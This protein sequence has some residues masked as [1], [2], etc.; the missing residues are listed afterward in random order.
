MTAARAAATAFLAS[1]TYLATNE[2]N[3]LSARQQCELH[4]VFTIFYMNA[5]YRAVQAARA[6]GRNVHFANTD[7]NFFD[8]MIKTGLHAIIALLPFPMSDMVWR[9]H[10]QIQAA[11]TQVLRR[12]ITTALHNHLSTALGNANSMYN[13][14]NYIDANGDYMNRVIGWLGC[15]LKFAAAKDWTSTTATA[16]PIVGI[17]WSGPS[18]IGLRAPPAL[19]WEDPNVAGSRALVVVAESRI[20]N[21]QLNLAFSNDLFGVNG[22]NLLAATGNAQNDIAALAL[23]PPTPV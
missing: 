6:A 18:P 15:T 3:A 23:V 19:L 21:C 1:G 13:H 11:N 8:V 2:I 7:K 5:L 16:T 20:N 17:N 14:A 10:E 12:V 22:N 4:G 9:F